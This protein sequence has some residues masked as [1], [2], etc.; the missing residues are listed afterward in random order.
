M[1]SSLSNHSD[2]PK[3]RGQF[4]TTRWSVVLSAGG[5]TDEERAEALEQLCFDYWY[6]LYA[7]LRRSGRSEE[8]AQD[9]T[10]GFFQMFLRR[11]D[12]Q[13]ANPEKGR[14]RSF[15]LTSLKNFVA[16]EWR[17]ERASK[18]GGSVERVS[19]DDELERRYVREPADEATPET[20]YERSWANSVLVIVQTKLEEEFRKTDKLELFKSLREHLGGGKGGG[21]RY[22]EI[23]A[24]HELT[25][26][27][28]P[29]QKLAQPK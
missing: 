14:F 21:A 27:L 19:M 26:G 2:A 4:L 28:P 22:A 12:F 8:D 7:Y 23:A 17:K 20:L 18:R 16:N 25:V 3:N 15:L 10:Q 13:R 6:S 11:G 29:F 24:A 9:L 5:Q 1:S